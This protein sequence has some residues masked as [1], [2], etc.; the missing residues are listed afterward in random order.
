M[1]QQEI[2]A[3]PGVV[4][5]GLGRIGQVEVFDLFYLFVV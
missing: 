1:A 3:E 4:G 2:A 5:F